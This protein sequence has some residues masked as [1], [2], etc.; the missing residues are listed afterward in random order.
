MLRDVHSHLGGGTVSRPGDTHH[1]QRLLVAAVIG[2][3]TVVPVAGAASAQRPSVSRIAVE[4]HRH[5]RILSRRARTCVRFPHAGPEA[6]VVLRD[7]RAKADA[8]RWLSASNV[9]GAAE[10]RNPSQYAEDI[11]GIVRAI[12]TQTP[13]QFHQHVHVTLGVLP[14]EFECPRARIELTVP[15]RVTP[16]ETAWADAEIKRWGADR[17]YVRYAGSVL[18]NS[19]GAAPE[20]GRPQRAEEAI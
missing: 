12:Q 8:L 16:A 10:V 14:G 20:S 7:R 3:L 17:V 19:R 13:P 5:E 11:E 6:I 1:F 2:A 4:L 18:T 15:G 9:R